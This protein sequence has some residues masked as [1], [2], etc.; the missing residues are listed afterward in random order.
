MTSQFN[1]ILSNAKYIYGIGKETDEAFAQLCMEKI[2]NTK[3]GLEFFYGY[4]LTE[5]QRNDLVNISDVVICYG[6]WKEDPVCFS[7]YTS[8][9]KSSKNCYE[10]T[11]NPPE[12]WY[13]KKL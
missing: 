6:D 11:N 12:G 3:E 8:V 2:N 9:I 1:V 5:E 13:M 10:I 4:K 7:Q